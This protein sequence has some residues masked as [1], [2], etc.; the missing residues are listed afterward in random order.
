MISNP[1]D[2]KVEILV[3]RNCLARAIAGR[4]RKL[5]VVNSLRRLLGR[6]CTAVLAHLTTLTTGLY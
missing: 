3:L 2:S 1:A 4:K 5:L 6:E